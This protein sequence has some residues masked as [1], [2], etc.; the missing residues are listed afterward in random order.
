MALACMR[1]DHWAS[2]AIVGPS[3]LSSAAAYARHL[4]PGNGFGR[5]A[6]LDLT[7][8][9][10]RSGAGRA[11]AVLRPDIFAALNR[12]F[13]LRSWPPPTVSRSTTTGSACDADP[14]DVVM[15]GVAV[16]AFRCVRYRRVVAAQYLHQ[17]GLAAPIRS[18]IRLNLRRLQR[19]GVAMDR[20]Q[21]LVRMA[22]SAMREN[23][24]PRWPS[25]DR[26]GRP[27]RYVW[28]AP[29]S[30]PV[31]VSLTASL[32]RRMCCVPL[33]AAAGNKAAIC[34]PFF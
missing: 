1:A 4:V 33:S 13:Q 30:G 27:A 20:L 32:P 22:T 10:N 17:Q 31:S 12:L 16:R 28:S 34:H 3:A 2:S 8:G 24:W 26:K 9:R 6:A 18:P 11:G 25:P 29:A 23:R 5:D 19:H 21:V 14:V 7:C 15:N